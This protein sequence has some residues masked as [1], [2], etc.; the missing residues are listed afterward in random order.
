MNI[1][2]GYWKKLG[3]TKELL[4]CPF[5]NIEFGVILLSRIRDRIEKPTV[6]KIA[7]IYNLLGARKVTDY[8][9]RVGRL[10]YLQPWRKRGCAV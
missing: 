3:V 2:Y 4:E 8:G 5:Y 9:A 6:R 10:Y 1:H 7:S